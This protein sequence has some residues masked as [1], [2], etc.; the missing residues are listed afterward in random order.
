MLISNFFSR[1]PFS[2]IIYF[3]IFLDMIY[4]LISFLVYKHQLN[5]TQLDVENQIK[6]HSK[7]ISNSLS[8]LI[9]H[10]IN[11]IQLDLFQLYKHY[12]INNFNNNQNIDCF[13]DNNIEDEELKDYLKELS[14]NNSY[15]IATI[16]K[17]ISNSTNLLINEY[18]NKLK[19]KKIFNTISYLKGTN[20]SE[21][22]IICYM[23]P[24][25]KS[26]M[27]RE[28]SIMKNNTL[29]NNIFFISQNYVYQYPPNNTT[30]LL[31]QN[32]ENYSKKITNCRYNYSGRCFME[33][34]NQNLKGKNTS[35]SNIIHI[36]NKDMKIFSCISIK[37]DINTNNDI[38]FICL[39]N[40]LENK[41]NIVKDFERKNNLLILA[42]IQNNSQIQIYFSSNI[43]KNEFMEIYSN[44]NKILG[45][46]SYLKENITLFHILYY[47]IFKYKKSDI[48]KDLI[49]N[50][51]NEYENISNTINK[52]ISENN[53]KSINLE[54]NLT[55]IDVNYNISGV[56]DYENGDIKK[57]TKV[58][59]EIT[60]ILIK[61]INYND[62]LILN[63]TSNKKDLF[64]FELNLFRFST[65]IFDGRENDIFSMKCI[66][67]FYIFFFILY[68]LTSINSTLFTKFLD[69]IFHPIIL[70]TKHLKKKILLKDSFQNLNLE[71]RKKNKEELNINSPN[72]EMQNLIQLCK[73]LENIIDMKKLI[74]T[75]DQIEIDFSLM[76]E[77]YSELTTNKEIINYGHFV[78]NFYFQ[79]G[80]YEECSNSIKIIEDI[81]YNEKKKIKNENENIEIEILNIL[82]NISYVNEFKKSN[83]IFQINNITNQKYYYDLL[84]ISEKLYFM[85]A[86]CLYFKA[87]KFKKDLKILIENEKKTK[88]H[89]NV[90]FKKKIIDKLKKNNIKNNKSSDNKEVDILEIKKEIISNFIKAGKYFKK[91]LDINKKFGINRIKSIIILIYLSKCYMQKNLFKKS[92]SIEAIKNAI[93]SLFNLNQYFIEMNNKIYL[94][95]RIMLLI[96]GIIFEQIMYNI[97]KINQNNNNDKL[98]AKLFLNSL[99]ISYFKTDNIQ[100]KSSKHLINLIKYSVSKNNKNLLL[101]LKKIQFRLNPK[102]IKYQNDFE[103]ISKNVFLLFS[104]KL[105]EIIPN[106]I[107]LCEII[108][109]CV[110]NYLN[111][112][113][114]IWC[115]RFDFQIE[116]PFKKANDISK[117]F[118][119]RILSQNYN[120]NYEKYGMQNSIFKIN[121][122]INK[123]IEEKKNLNNNDIFDID[124]VNK[125]N[126]DDENIIFDDNYIFQFILLSDYSFD[127]TNSK[128][129]FKKF[130]NN[131]NISLYTFVFDED[132]KNRKNCFKEIKFNRIIHNLKHIPEGVL[133]YVNNFNLIKLAFQNISRIYFNKNI[134]NINFEL[135]KN[136]FLDYHNGN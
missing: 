36:L 80:K 37:K 131:N 73:F 133:I 18:L 1:K 102:I 64:C 75:K 123:I 130:L 116:F 39:E 49:N 117:D 132:F 109:N 71:K 82:T 90:I 40:I 76:N 79:K 52:A 2:I 28:I 136:I 33:E 74:Q 30:L 13:L 31:L 44:Y 7:E 34:L 112:N 63:L 38:N 51:I 61:N 92:D 108:S 4:I 135:N 24:I 56:L 127:S 101:H 120:S 100:S 11:K 20:D 23:I 17:N 104:N 25:L 122:I 67:S 45:N 129:K 10:I 5:N 8:Q 16:E 65:K 66:K 91:S 128:D 110:K 59:L 134:F 95:P 42:K 19:K 50:L 29:L 35:N 78:S 98:S 32:I 97:A 121:I 46:Y 48:T 43:N 124:R 93:I 12:E 58:F 3:C 53:K 115:N 84:I 14:K 105:I 125:N 27:F 60:P 111:K 70:L 41:L 126:L 6:I 119:M 113:D 69:S 87:K 96:N 107:E 88:K 54:L 83:E 47:E 99:S 114:N 62:Q 81:L 21:R 77:I 106:K 9:I 118:L 68:F 94:N 15:P 26:I 22:H 55:F 57:N 89:K 103:N 85:N 72:P 86:I